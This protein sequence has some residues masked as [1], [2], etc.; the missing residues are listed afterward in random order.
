MRV[1][2]RTCKHPEKSAIDAA[3]RAGRNIAA[4]AAEYGLPRRT[5]GEHA[6]RHMGAAPPAAPAPPAPKKKA[7]KARPKRSS[8]N[9]ARLLESKLWTLLSSAIKADRGDVPE[10]S[11]EYRQIL[12]QYRIWEREEV[13]ERAATEAS[14]PT[15]PL[16]IPGV[17][18]LFE[19]AIAI[20]EPYGPALDVLSA[21]FEAKRASYHN[22]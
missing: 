8:V 5:L 17:V 6:S 1:R 19:E 9:Q 2:C 21:W 12:A 4:L 11:R 16:D 22:E 20:L 15:R 3:L 14:K 13:A 10:L 7:A 18:E